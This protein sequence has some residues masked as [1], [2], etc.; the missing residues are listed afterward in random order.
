LAFL[1]GALSAARFLGLPR[2]LKKIL[3]PRRPP[4]PPGFSLTV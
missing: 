3:A 4:P 1:V 2:V